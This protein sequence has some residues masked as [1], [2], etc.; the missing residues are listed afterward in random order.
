MS[1]ARTVRYLIASC[2]LVMSVVVLSQARAFAG[3]NPANSCVAC[4]VKNPHPFVTGS[5]TRKGGC[6]GPATLHL[7]YYYPGTP[8]PDWDVTVNT[9][10]EAGSSSVYGDSGSGLI[11]K[12]VDAPLNGPLPTQLELILYNW[13][14]FQAQK[15]LDSKVIPIPQCTI[16]RPGGFP[17]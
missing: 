7:H 3:L 15:W 5:V 11:D 2:L 10:T 6:A 17:H 13:E 12:T 8:Q 1:L 14:S 4:P 9:H 16:I